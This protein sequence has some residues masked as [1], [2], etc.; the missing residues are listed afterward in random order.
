M[1]DNDLDSTDD[2]FS[3]GDDQL[4][5]QEGLGKAKKIALFVIVPILILAGIGVGLYA[6]GVLDGLFEKG[7]KAKVEKAQKDEEEKVE[8]KAVFLPIPDIVVNLKSQ[9]NQTRF[10]RLR[11]QIELK[12]EAQ[13]SSVEQVMPR[14]VDQ[15]QTYLREMRIEDLKGS[16]GIYRLQ[17]EL[18]SRVN[19]AA[20]PIEVQD[21]L[22]QEMLIQ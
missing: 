22:F 14:V 12:S 18:I 20:Y 19:A 6:S 2:D 8:F 5:E 3:E 10:L 1:S 15:F 4:D 13:K 21:V 16:A 7:D 11:V 17:K 9:D